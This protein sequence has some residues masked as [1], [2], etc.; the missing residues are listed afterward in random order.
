MTVSIARIFQQE[1]LNFAITNR[2]PRRLATRALGQVSRIESARFVNLALWVWKRFAPEL[3]LSEA[4]R[5][6]FRSLRE[7]F[8]RELR[9]GSRPIV[10]D[11]AVVV[12]PCDAVVGACGPVREGTLL[13]AKGL[14]YRLG[15]LLRCHLPNCS[16][17]RTPAEWATTWCQPRDGR[18]VRATGR[19]AS[20]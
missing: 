15:E 4:R 14:S 2:I 12:S 19:A 3:D 20:P 10:E 1:D 11:P 13:Q 18:P 9:P 6:E 7:C 5:S 17:R 8:I 16:E